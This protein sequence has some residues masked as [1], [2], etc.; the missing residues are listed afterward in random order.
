MTT[1]H[2][3]TDIETRVFGPHTKPQ[4]E[5]HDSVLAAIGYRQPSTDLLVSRETFEMG[6]LEPLSRRVYADAA[7]R[8]DPRYPPTKADRDAVKKKAYHKKRRTERKSAIRIRWRSATVCAYPGN[9][10]CYEPTTRLVEEVKFYE[11]HA[12]MAEKAQ[13]LHLA[14]K[15]Y[16]K[17]CAWQDGPPC[18]E[19]RAKDLGDTMFCSK[20]TS[21]HMIRMVRQGAPQ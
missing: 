8:F 15:R 11:K 3:H 18:T 17:V 14:P 13:I 1:G 7:G 4:T 19:Y 10:V 9:V 6:R 12:A 21:E 20:H 2:S 16:G 5:F